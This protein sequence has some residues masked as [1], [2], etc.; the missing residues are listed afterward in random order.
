MPFVP[1]ESLRARLGRE[2]MLAVDEAVRI[3]LEVADALGYA[4]GLGIVHRD[5]KPENILL[6]GGHALVA[7]L[8]IA[9]AVTEAGGDKLTETGIAVGTPAY[10]SPEQSAGEPAGPTSDLYSLGC[11]L[12]EMLAG[13]PPYSAASARQLMARHAMEPV[14]RLQ[15]VRNTVSAAVEDAVTAALG[16]LPA[17]R[18][19]TAAE[20]AALLN[21]ASASGASR[22]S[23]ARTLVSRH[24]ASSPVGT[25][26]VTLTVG[27]RS[28]LTAG[29]A[30]SLGVA[31]LLAGMV[32]YVREHTLRTP[33]DVSS[34]SAARQRNIAVLYFRDESPQQDLGEVTDGLTEALIGDL[35]SVP[36]LSVVSAGGVAQFRG[37]DVRWDSLARALGVGTLVQGAV[38]PEGDA[39]SISVRIRTGGSEG[40]RP[41]LGIRSWLAR[42]SGWIS[43]CSR[44]GSR[45]PLGRSAPGARHGT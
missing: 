20:V 7:D 39:G 3:A 8:G 5:I 25:Q 45:P 30:V 15:V 44:S 22:F 18:P 27:R 40:C 13:Q 43:R 11:V 34:V 1:G 6:S 4:H 10:M 31:L 9:R 2:H 33:D 24:T 19:K 16:K 32:W 28:L 36:G 41:T 21:G 23:A 38:E 26:A 12:Y 17:D 29:I 42:R 37:Q 35:G 14:P